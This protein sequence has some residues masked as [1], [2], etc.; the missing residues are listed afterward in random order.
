MKHI[1]LLLLFVL[2]STGSIVYSQGWVA[3]TSGTTWDLY[4][5]C[6]VDVNTGWA[7]SMGGYTITKTTDGGTSW[8]NLDVHQTIGVSCK[9]VYFVNSSTGWTVTDLGVY[10]TT[11][12]G[13]TWVHQYTGF[14]TM[15]SIYFLNSTTGWAIGESGTSL[16]TTDGGTNWTTTTIGTSSDKWYSVYFV[17]SN[18]G[19]AV[20]WY[21]FIDKTT[22][23]GTTWVNQLAPL[24]SDL[25]SVFFTSN[26]TGWVVGK[27]GT[28]KKT[29]N[30]G[31]NWTKLTS[32]T[33][34]DLQSIFFIDSSTGWVVGKGG[35]VLKTIDGG[36]NWTSQS[37]GTTKVLYSVCFVDT[38]TGWT[39]GEGGTILKTT[40]S[41]N[42]T[43][44]EQI[45]STVPQKFALLQNYPNPFN[46]S[47]TISYQLSVTSDVKLGVF[48]LLGRKVTT[49]MNEVQTAGVHQITF[50]AHA[51]CS[52]MY[53][54]KLTA[55]SFTQVKKM[56]LTK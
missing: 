25:K 26:T 53:F 36:S 5:V 51:L 19:W 14:S 31:T 55:G 47:T 6:F 4:S 3:Q 7:V 29:S 23:G 18:T 40:T 10:K 46:P 52:G 45:E 30:G 17:D 22:D 32:G 37:S 27:S 28:I 39:V 12:G 9:S 1:S 35:T 11:D 15:W 48:D 38:N 41:G 21:G 2:I 13:T 54:Y 33:T 43:S 16:K 49:L 24:T 8:V 44:V 20:G 56:T 42:A 34:T 50:D